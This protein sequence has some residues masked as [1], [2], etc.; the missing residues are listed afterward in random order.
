MVGPTRKGQAM[1]NKKSGIL[2][3]VMNK[4]LLRK[5]AIEETLKS[6]VDEYA[7]KD[8]GLDMMRLLWATYFNSVMEKCSNCALDA[9]NGQLNTDLVVDCLKTTC[10]QYIFGPALARAARHLAYEVK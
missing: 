4:D 7:A 9:T 10:P 3:F 1:P 2:N 6:L 5:K 8:A